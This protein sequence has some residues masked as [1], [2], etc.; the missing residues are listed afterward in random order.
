MLNMCLNILARIG[1]PWTDAYRPGQWFAPDPGIGARHSTTALRPS[2]LF[3]S[4]ISRRP[5]KRLFETTIKVALVGKA[6]FAG[7]FS[8]RQRT[9]LEQTHRA[10]KSNVGHVAD[11]RGSGYLFE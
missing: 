9:A 6:Y 3:W 8:N 2:W 1:R 4:K 7:H 10:G 5:L 11:K